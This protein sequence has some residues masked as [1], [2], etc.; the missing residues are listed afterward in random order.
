MES[1]E[2]GAQCDSARVRFTEAA[3]VFFD[4][5]AEVQLDEEHSLDEQRYTVVGQSIRMQTLFVVHLV[6]KERIRIVSARK[7]TPQE[8]RQYE[9]KLGR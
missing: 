5:Q 2:S 3:T 7:A 6:K 8:R 4:S 9:F 1:R